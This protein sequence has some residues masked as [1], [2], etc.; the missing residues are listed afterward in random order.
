MEADRRAKRVTRAESDDG[1]IIALLLL[2]RKAREWHGG[3]EEKKESAGYVRREAVEV[4]YNLSNGWGFSHLR[5]R[6][7]GPIFL[8]LNGYTIVLV[9]DFFGS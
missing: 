3:E 2:L 1:Y 7:L 5:F 4:N 9:K 8:L 6:A